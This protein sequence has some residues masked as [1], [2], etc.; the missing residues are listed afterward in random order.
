MRRVFWHDDGHFGSDLGKKST[1]NLAN[2]LHR[3][4]S[5][6]AGIFDVFV[7]GTQGGRTGVLVPSCIIVHN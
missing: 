5:G 2:I 3:L 7:G 1:L 4:V 6:R